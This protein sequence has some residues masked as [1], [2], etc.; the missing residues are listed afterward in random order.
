[1]T[2]AVKMLVF[3]GARD[4]VGVGELEVPLASPCSAGELL[5][6]MCRRFPGLAPY[7]ASLRIAVNGSYVTLADPVVP[8]DEV[9]LIPP[10]AG[11]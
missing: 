10:V 5:A 1:M 4:I 11:G 3:A 9:A 7:G 8:G 2:P 6:E